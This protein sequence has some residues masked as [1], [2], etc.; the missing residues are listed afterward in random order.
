MGRVVV[1][2]VASA[3]TNASRGVALLRPL[4]ARLQSQGHDVEVV[5]VGG[6]TL[7]GEA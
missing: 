6:D 3:M 1:V 4:I 2:D 7:T 5:L